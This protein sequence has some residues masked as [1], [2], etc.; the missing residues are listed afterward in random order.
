ML[1]NVVIFLKREMSF[2]VKQVSYYDISYIRKSHLVPA[3]K[4]IYT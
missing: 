1:K 2:F 3:W 4:D